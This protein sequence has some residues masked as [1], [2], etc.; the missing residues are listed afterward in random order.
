MEVYYNGLTE[1][2]YELRQVI[3]KAIL[4]CSNILG[5]EKDALNADV[6]LPCL[7]KHR[8]KGHKLHPVILSKN[9]HPLAV[10]CSIEKELPTIKLTD[11]RQTCWLIG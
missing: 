3:C 2:C 1:N 11:P 8:L 10:R 5:Y 4:T 7:R 9:N 6:T